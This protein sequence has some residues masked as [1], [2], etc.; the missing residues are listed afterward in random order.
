MLNLQY[1]KFCFKNKLFYVK[2]VKNT[3]FIAK[4]TKNDKKFS[5][6]QYLV[7]FVGEIIK[8]K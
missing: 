4:I 5:D 6:F 1:K 3:F 2:F 7:Y 8:L